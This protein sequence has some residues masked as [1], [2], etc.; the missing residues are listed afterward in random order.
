VSHSAFLGSFTTLRQIPGCRFFPLLDHFF[1]HAVA[2]LITIIITVMKSSKQKQYS[3]IENSRVNLL[4][5]R[6]STLRVSFFLLCLSINQVRYIEKGRGRFFP[7][8]YRVNMYS[9]HPFDVI[10]PYPRMWDRVLKEVHTQACSI[11]LSLRVNGS[12]WC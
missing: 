10:R 1:R 6:L 12:N 2:I 11:H 3:L 5:R 8:I 4:S 9:S 7:D